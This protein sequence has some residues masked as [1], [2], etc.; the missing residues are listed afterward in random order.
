M[1]EGVLTCA[2]RGGTTMVRARRWTSGPAAHVSPWPRLG[3]AKAG[4]YG[5][6]RSRLGRVADE[7]GRDRARGLDAGD[8]ISVGDVTYLLMRE[9][10]ILAKV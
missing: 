10:D 3:L 8:E 7:I 2:V 5:M 4:R 1:P 6:N 9:S